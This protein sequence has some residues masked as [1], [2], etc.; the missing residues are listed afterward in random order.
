[1]NTEKTESSDS[2]KIKPTIQSFKDLRVWQKSMSIA[3]EIYKASKAF[4]R[5]ELYGL[6]SQI[7]KS[8]VSVPSNIA[9][10]F[11]RW[12]KTEFK[13]FLHISLGSLAELETQL[14][15]A[16]S[17]GYVEEKQ[18][19]KLIGEILTCEKMISKLASKYQ[20]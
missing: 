16:A 5:E 18:K 10:G 12:H 3:S 6:T 14:L 4:P 20:R 9:E 13:Q 19:E 7:R 8:A 15:L 11:K 2:I 17:F 1:M